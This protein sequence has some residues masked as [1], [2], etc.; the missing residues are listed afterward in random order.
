MHQ[1]GFALARYAVG[2]CSTQAMSSASAVAHL[3]LTDI[4]ISDTG[5]NVLDRTSPD[6]RIHANLGTMMDFVIYRAAKP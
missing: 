5:I 4:T 3:L 6:G 1:P 2:E